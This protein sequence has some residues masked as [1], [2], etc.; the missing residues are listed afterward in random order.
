M[1]TVYSQLELASLKM[2]NE[3]PQAKK[4]MKPFRNTFD[5]DDEINSRWNT[6]VA[7]LDE[8]TSIWTKR[9]VL[10]TCPFIDAQG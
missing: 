8:N 5:S 7:D 3:Q 6:D 9:R 10:F 4:G 1:S 2:N